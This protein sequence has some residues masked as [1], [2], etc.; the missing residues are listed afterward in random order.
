MFDF[1][2]AAP[3]I[4]ATSPGTRRELTRVRVRL[5]RQREHVSHRRHELHVPRPTASREPSRAS[6]SFRKYTSSPSG[7]PRSSATS[8]APSSTSSPGRAAIACWSDASYY[9]QPAG[10]TS[11][12]VRLAIPGSGDRVS[13][14]ERARYRDVTTNLGGPV[15]RDRLWFFAGYQYL[16]DYDSQPATDPNFPRVYEQNKVFAKLT[17]RLAPAW[18]LVQS[19]HDEHWVNPEVPTSVKPFD[20]TLRQQRVRAGDHLRPSDPHV[21]RQYAVGGARRAVRLSRRR[22]SPSSGNR[23]TPSRFDSVTGVTSGAPQQVGGAGK[24]AR[25]PRRPSATIGRR[26]GVRITSGRSGVQFERGEH[27]A[28]QVIPTGT[29]YTDNNGQPSQSTSRDPVQRRRSVHHGWRV[30]ERRPDDREPADDQCRRAFRPH[31]RH[32]PGPARARCRRTRD[33]GRHQRSGTL[34][35]WNVVS[36]RLG[37]TAKLSCRRPDIAPRQ[38]REIQPGRDDRGARAIPSRSD[39]RSRREASIRRP[40]ATRRVISVVDPKRNLQLDPGMRPPRTDQYSIGVDRE[41]G[42]Q[43][44]I[45][46]AYVRKEGDD[47]IGWTDVGGQ[48]RAETRTLPDGQHAAGVGARQRHRRSPLPADQSRRLFADVQRPRDRRRK[49]PVQRL[50]GVRL[51][52]LLEGLRTAGVQRDDRRRPAGQHRWRPARSV[53]P[54]PSRSGAIPT[55]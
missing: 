33:R 43:I 50:A 1:I 46:I 31:P 30:R 37:A 51:L 18:Q 14:Y 15:V 8:R 28:L 53:R 45:G 47:F 27:R 25:P 38:L 40:A 17:W 44:A 3:G 55:I 9:G 4:S 42:R 2:G 54:D 12:P 5:R 16:R 41:L 39:A 10:L 34:Y 32:Q 26:C 35:T 48:Y 11:Q 20:A 6:T 22:R 19:V 23:R 52:H 13:G 21:V 49:T 7:R 36:P 24:S 29:W